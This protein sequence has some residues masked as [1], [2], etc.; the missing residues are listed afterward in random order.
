MSAAARSLPALTSLRFFAAAYVVVHHLIDF[1]L[2]HQQIPVWRAR[3]TWYLAWGT[4]GHVGVTFFFVLSGFI[5]AWSY[6]AVFSQQTMERGRLRRFWVARIARVWPMHALTFVWFL[7]VALVAVTDGA[8]AWTVAWTGALNLLLLHAWPPVGG[9]DGLAATFNDPAWTLSV[10][11]FFYVVFPAIVWVP[12]ARLRWGVMRLLALATVG[13]VCLGVAGLLLQHSE[14]GYW[15]VRVFPPLRLPDFVL[16]LCLGLVFVQMAPHTLRPSVW[17]TVLEVMALA[18][19]AAALLLW[20][21]ML[22]DAVPRTLTISFVYLPVLG[23]LVYVFACGRGAVTRLLSHPW[24]V[25]LGE[26]SYALYLV[27]FFLIRAAYKF[28]LYDTLG[29][30]G[31]TLALIAATI[32]VAGVCHVWF[33]RPARR[34]ITE[35]WGAA[36]G[37][38]G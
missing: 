9:P 32:A 13:W 37:I 18:L 35:R 15:A 26:I 21:T 33:E 30:W 23:W 19:V 36:S 2:L 20:S 16:G 10:E 5:L 14:M 1:A 28:G 17:G 34:W 8:G 12:A 7:G 24:C 27:H 31:T 38:R 6:H 4:Q 22:A 3:D 11:A 25:W 29:I